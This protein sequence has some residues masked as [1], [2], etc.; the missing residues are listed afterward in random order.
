MRRTTPLQT[1]QDTAL[2]TPPQ[3]RSALTS[4]GHAAA[5]AV[6]VFAVAQAVDEGAQ[7]VHVA[8]LPSHHHLLVD[9][10]GLG[11]VRPLL[12]RTKTTTGSPGGGGG[13]ASAFLRPQSRTR[14]APG[15]MLSATAV[16]AL[17]RL[18]SR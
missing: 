9:D 1:T 17:A 11:Q 4:V 18:P 8:H 16:L 7:L 13:G 6:G 10:V 14:N 15:Q 3:T 12:Q 2:E 5:E